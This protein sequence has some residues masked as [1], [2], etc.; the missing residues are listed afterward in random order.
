MFGHSPTSRP[1]GQ[2]GAVQMTIGVADGGG[3]A[4]GV[5]VSSQEVANAR[6][7]APGRL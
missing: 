5:A 4:V 3:V 7:D 2:A 6:R 1:H